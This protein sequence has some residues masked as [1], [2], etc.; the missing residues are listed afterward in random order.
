MNK[1]DNYYYDVC[2]DRGTSIYHLW[3]EQ[4]WVN[5]SITPSVHVP[6]YQRLISEQIALLT[7]TGSQVFSL[8]CGNGF[9]EA[10]L[11]RAGVPVKAIDLNEVAAELARRKGVDAI[12]K[13]FF[14]TT[15]ADFAG[16]GTIYS[17]GF[18]GHLFHPETGLDD[19]FR[20]LTTLAIAPG[21]P[22]IISNDAPLDEQRLFQPHE[23]VPD[24]WY[25][26]PAYLEEAGCKWG[27][28]PKLSQYYF[29]SRPVS[30][31]RKRTIYICTF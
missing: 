20:H 6:E 2:R 17:D 7:H 16:V 31:V 24:F 29:Y 25:V 27:L 28:T 4:N 8:G 21:T 30:G 5:D 9:V 22:L 13:N 10:M 1:D 18:V 23:K 11:V 26:S 19:F 15:A 3:E 14:D 12:Q